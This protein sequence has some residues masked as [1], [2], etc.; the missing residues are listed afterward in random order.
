MGPEND[1]PLF[2]LGLVLPPHMAV[3]LHLFEEQELLVL[4][5]S[6]ARLEK[7]IELLHEKIETL[8]AQKEIRRVIGGNGKVRDRVRVL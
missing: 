4:P 2:P 6:S 3:P 5:S 8:K 1:I 7:V